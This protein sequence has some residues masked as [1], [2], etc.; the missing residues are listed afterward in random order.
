[1]ADGHLQARKALFFRYKELEVIF[2]EAQEIHELAPFIVRITDHV[3]SIANIHVLWSKQS[4]P[5]GLKTDK[6]NEP[7]NLEIRSQVRRVRSKARL[8]SVLVETVQRFR[9]VKN[10]LERDGT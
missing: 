4:S 3:F 8:V 1:M 2:F 5:L 10:R 9:E 7:E 6:V